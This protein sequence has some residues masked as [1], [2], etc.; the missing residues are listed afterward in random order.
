[1][2]LIQLRLDRFVV[3]GKSQLWT[4][5]L[6]MRFD[7]NG[8]TIGDKSFWPVSRAPCDIFPFDNLSH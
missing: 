8:V 2:Q 6:P 3:T 1:M 4:L 7:P 5:Q